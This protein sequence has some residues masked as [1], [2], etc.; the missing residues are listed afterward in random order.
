MYTYLQNK[1][2]LLGKSSHEIRYLTNL[3]GLVYAGFSSPLVVCNGG[4]SSFSGGVKHTSNSNNS[5][6]GGQMTQQAQ[7]S[8]QTQFNGM[9]NSLASKHGGDQLNDFEDVKQELNAKLLE[10]HPILQKISKE[11]LNNFVWVTLNNYVRDLQRKSITRAKYNRKLKTEDYVNVDGEPLTWED[12]AD[13]AFMALKAYVPE[14]HQSQDESCA[15]AELVAHIM[16]WAEYKGGAIAVIMKE[17]INPSDATLGTWKTM[18]DK[19]P[20]YKKFSLI[21]PQT[22]GKILGYSPATVKKH[23]DRLKVHLHTVGYTPAY[24]NDLFNTSI[25]K[26]NN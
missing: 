9:I 23:M 25:Y 7:P 15:Y 4:L 8:H 5:T 3:V 19:F 12:A 10:I 24:L 1:S 2:E 18:I 14:H 21:P 13:N 6:T 20:T 17:M 16:D 22:L 26:G 11:E